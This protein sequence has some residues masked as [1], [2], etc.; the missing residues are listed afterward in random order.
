MRVLC[1]TNFYPPHEIGGEAQSCQD[2]VQALR[3]RGHQVAVLTSTHGV[4]GAAPSRDGVIRELKLEME[5][6]SLHAVRFFVSRRRRE[7]ACHKVLQR[8]VGRWSPDVLFVWGMWNLPRSV[9]SLA[10]DLRPGKVA[11]RFADYWATLPSQHEMYWRGASGRPGMAWLKRSLA[12]LALSQIAAEAPPA[13]L[14]L[15]NAYCI[16]LSMRRSLI[17]KGLRLEGAPVTYNGVDTELFHPRPPRARQM[18]PLNLVYAGRLAAEKG[19]HTAVEAMALLVAAGHGACVRL[20]I[21]GGGEGGYPA[22]LQDEVISIGLSDYVS[23]RGSVAKPDM[24]AALREFDAL[25]FTSTWSE[26]FGRVLI[27]AM[28]SGLALVAAKVGAVPEIATDGEDALFFAPGDAADLAAKVRRLIDDPSLGERLAVA[29]RRTVE[30]RFTKVRMVEE[31]E[32]YLN[33]AARG[34]APISVGA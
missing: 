11:Y 21:I 7:V 2:V 27:E 15:Q 3:M 32:A 8:A 23:F 5:L 13:P 17:G 9:L 14:N 6:G 34:M 26:P 28:A 24:P 4:R 16:S 19:V 22:R 18:R 25:L 33:E 10:E 31:V 1:L 30:E 12:G 29:G 20:A